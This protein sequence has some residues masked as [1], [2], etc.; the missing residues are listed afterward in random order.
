MSH[1]NPINTPPDPNNP[2]DLYESDRTNN[3]Y[4]L[5]YTVEEILLPD[6]IIEDAYMLPSDT[7]QQ[8]SNNSINQVFL[9]IKNI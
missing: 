2:A 9:T 5:N 1:P 3:S 6:V 4:I 7:P 8:R